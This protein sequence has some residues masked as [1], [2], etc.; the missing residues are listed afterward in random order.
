MVAPLERPSAGHALTGDGCGA[1]ELRRQWRAARH[2]AAAGRHHRCRVELNNGDRDAGIQGI[3]RVVVDVTL[4]D[5]FELIA[6]QT[7]SATKNVAA[8]ELTWFAIKAVE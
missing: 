7:S 2:R 5:Y 6:R 8:D 1:R 4:G 3:G